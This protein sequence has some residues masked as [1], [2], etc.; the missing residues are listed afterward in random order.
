MDYSSVPHRYSS[1]QLTFG[2]RYRYSQCLSISTRSDVVVEGIETFL[3]QLQT[4]SPLPP[5]VELARTNATVFILDND[6]GMLH[7]N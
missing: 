4:I 3:V 7:C 1:G 2:D 6:H 5:Y